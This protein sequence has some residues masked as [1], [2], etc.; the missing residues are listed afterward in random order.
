MTTKIEHEYEYKHKMEENLTSLSSSRRETDT[1]LE[2]L[3]H[4]TRYSS[5]L[6]IFNGWVR[7][8]IMLLKQNTDSRQ[9]SDQVYKTITDIS[10]FPPELIE[11]AYHARL[12]YYQF[13]SI[14]QT[15]RICDSFVKAYI[16]PSHRFIESVRKQLCS[17]IIISKP[18]P[19]CN[20]YI[21]PVCHVH[22]SSSSS[23]SSS[24]STLSMKTTSVTT[25]LS[26][27]SDY[28][29]GQAL[30]DELLTREQQ[31]M[32]INNTSF[33]DR[34]NDMIVLG[35]VLDKKASQIYKHYA[36]RLLWIILW[37]SNLPSVKT[38]TMLVKE[39]QRIIATRLKPKFDGIIRCHKLLCS[40]LVHKRVDDE[41]LMNESIVFAT[42]KIWMKS[43][44]E[45]VI[46]TTCLTIKLP[47]IIK[48]DSCPKSTEE[49]H[50]IIPH[51][52]TDDN[53]L[54][55]VPVLDH[56]RFIEEGTN[57]LD[58]QNEP[59][60]SR[61]RYNNRTNQKSK[62]VLL[63][64]S[65]QSLYGLKEILDKFHH[66][67][68]ET[69]STS[70]FKWYSHMT[71]MGIFQEQ[72]RYQHPSSPIIDK[73]LHIQ[74]EFKNLNR[75]TSACMSSIGDQISAVVDL[76]AHIKHETMIVYAKDYKKITDDL[77]HKVEHLLLL[78]RND[79]HIVNDNGN[80]DD[81]NVD[82]DAE[83]ETNKLHNRRKDIRHSDTKYHHSDYI[84]TKTNIE[85]L[86]HPLLTAT[87]K[88]GRPHIV[89]R[90]YADL[91]I[92]LGCIPDIL[93]SLA[94]NLPTRTYSMCTTPIIHDFSTLSNLDSMLLQCV[95]ECEDNK[96]DNITIDQYLSNFLNL[97]ERNASV[98]RMFNKLFDQYSTIMNR[99]FIHDYYHNQEQQILFVVH[100]PSMVD[101][102]DQHWREF[103]KI[104]LIP[105]T[106]I[107]Q[108]LNET[109]Y[110][111]VLV[112]LIFEFAAVRL[113][114]PLDHVTVSAE[115]YAV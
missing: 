68:E 79:P 4:L 23:S 48:T 45:R 40:E 70:C 20:G 63:T 85:H 54:S 31:L 114:N 106:S 56:A 98:Y 55:L 105:I 2:T 46:G 83:S 3:L 28:G 7:E 10:D 72:S 18:F 91:M 62:N 1:T 76:L 99:D 51:D 12:E 17:V 15:F 92:T 30:F 87:V 103:G 27:L 78:H 53:I 33:K 26:I 37:V 94:T 39:R 25:V 50:H 11:A 77:I 73:L 110:P 101:I 93:G 43:H 21:D 82:T 57:W 29:R 52:F 6:K 41:T 14:L 16:H 100:T 42:T 9:V 102:V 49:S 38:D 107:A 84:G 81:T 44:G 5:I 58:T 109:R 75:D 13:Y 113:V 67:T 80:I 34:L 59:H 66:L 90:L 112:L 69:R 60:T 96:Q 71:N 88:T 22:T 35:S 24:S 86:I 47:F 19:Q 115:Y 36:R 61:Y 97:K 74:S 65:I 89:K 64:T 95:S 8:I 108:F 104:S 111:S 32:L